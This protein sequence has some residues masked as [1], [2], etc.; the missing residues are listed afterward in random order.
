MINLAEK[1][2]SKID[3][4]INNGALSE[5]GVG[6]VTELTELATVDCAANPVTDKVSAE[7][8]GERIKGMVSLLTTAL[9]VIE[10]GDTV[11]IGGV[12]YKALSVNHYSD[13]DSIT[14][15]RE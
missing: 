12:S 5:S 8:Y 7:L 3:E 4:I 15:E 10:V 13:H 6:T 1:Y 9:N 14:A 2:S 11:K